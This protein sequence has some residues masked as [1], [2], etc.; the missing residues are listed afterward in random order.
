MAQN[1]IRVF[2]LQERSKKLAVKSD[3]PIQKVGKVLVVGAGLMG[4]G[5]AQWLSAR[6]LRVVLKDIGPE[7]LGKGLQ[8]IY[9]IY[10][11]TVK[12][13][14]FSETEAQAGF[15]RIL[16]AYE[17]ITLRVGDWVFQAPV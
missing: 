17:D 15:A 10:R 5:I 7:P 11:D 12:R 8:S 16:P 2:S 13:R 4:S 9:K 1:L 14:I 3:Q 6:G